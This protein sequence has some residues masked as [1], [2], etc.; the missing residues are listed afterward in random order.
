[1]KTK[2]LIIIIGLISCI[3]TFAQIDNE[4][5]FYTTITNANFNKN[6]VSD[7]GVDNDFTTDDSNQLQ[8]AINDISN[9]GGGTLIIPAGN[10]T[11]EEISLKSNVHI[12]IHKD[13]TIRPTDR[14][15]TKNYGIFNLGP[16][17]DDPIENVTITTRSSGGR[18]TVDLRQVNNMNVGVYRCSKVTN[19]IIANLNVEDKHT[20]FSLLATG[21]DEYNG[22]YIFPVNGIVKDIH[23]NNA[24]YG[25]GNVQT[26]SAENIL[27][28]DL[29]GNGGATL[30][31]ETGFTGLNN[32]QGTNLPS[33]VKRVGG[34]HKIVG[35]NISST[36][37]NSA[38]M[39]SP[40]ALHNGTVDIE[41]VI[42]VNSGFAIRIEGGFVSN[43]YDQNIGL[44]DGTF[45]SVR[46]KD[47]HAT[48]GTSAEIKSKHFK[49]YP[50]EITAPT[51]KSNYDDI[52]FIG[53]SITT[54]LADANYRCTNGVQT[55]VV[56]EPIIGVG[57]QFQEDIIPAEFLTTDCAALSVEDN[58][59]ANINIE[60][61][62][63]PSKNEI[64]I[65]SN[66]EIS[67][68]EIFSIAGKKVKSI[69]SKEQNIKINTSKMHRGIY[70]ARV[71]TEKGWYSVKKILIE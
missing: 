6:L 11:F 51:Q 60:V 39:V 3:S 16:K 61:Y 56:E 28:K 29:S 23:I 48:F 9:N 42:A 30:R 22:N 45:E 54:V 63:I 37:G 25:Y 34:I 26:Q 55:L 58:L 5:N 14:A 10:Y 69:N 35:R 67:K 62:P 18:F 20:K 44:D 19:F 8:T 50:P 40:H 1:M 65:K 2:L 7:Y 31:L 24:H 46:V 27:F 21:G 36:N 57:F 52:I 53:S 32:L 71:Y 43:K 41:G 13:V 64:T 49:Y 66:L 70:F 12:D 15:D 33:G 59:T 68:I 38:V 4:S 17:G 47:V